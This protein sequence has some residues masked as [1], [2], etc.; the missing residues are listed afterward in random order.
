MAS[1]L[2]RAALACALILLVPAVPAATA[3]PSGAERAVL[4]QVNQYRAAH[5]ATPVRLSRSL[6][7]SARRHS[8]RILRVNR[9]HHRRRISARGR[10]R[11]LG[12]NIAWLRGNRR[13]AARVVRMWA[14]SASHRQV[15]LNPRFRLGGVGRVYG[16]LGRRAATVWTLH[17]GRK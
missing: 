3:A 10:W 14:G 8:K 16:R 12:E 15:M 4:A 7:S 6:S 1:C 13:S 2:R 5:G 17:L 9:P 11:L